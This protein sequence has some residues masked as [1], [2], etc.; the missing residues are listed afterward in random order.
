MKPIILAL[1]LATPVAQAEFVSG[2][3]LLSRMNGQPMEQVF[4]SGYVAGVFDS[5]RGA[6][7]ICPPDGVTVGQV[8][9]MVRQLLVSAPS[10]R[11]QPGNRFVVAALTTAWP[12]KQQQSAPAKPQSTI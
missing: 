7:L 1:A 11:H 9:D 6:S 2:N 12:C 3:D 4:A 8:R 5:L 10:E